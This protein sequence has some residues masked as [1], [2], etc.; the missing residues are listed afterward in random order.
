MV[1]EG[2]SLGKTLA[3]IAAELSLGEPAVSRALSHMERLIGLQIVDRQRYRLRLTPT[4]RDL[5]L[6]AGQAARQLRD[7]DDLV[8]RYRRGEAGRLRVLSSNAPASY[9]LPQ[10]INDFLERFP[11][12]EIQLDVEGA[13]NIWP[14]FAEGHHDVAVGPAEGPENVARTFL[15]DGVWC[16]EPLY[17]DR[18]VLFVSAA[19]PLHGRRGITLQALGAHTIVGT[20]G[21][22]DW[23]RLLNRLAARG[24]KVGRVVALKSVEGVKRLVESGQGVGVY[25]LSAIVR[26]VREG[27][28]VTLNLPDL[29]PPYSYILVRRASQGQVPLV[30]AFCQLVRSR[31]PEMTSLSGRITAGVTPEVRARPPR[32]SFRVP[33]DSRRPQAGRARH[34]Q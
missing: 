12:A 1:L 7:F 14:A 9:L 33:S 16:S 28:L 19:H 11:K 18:I 17:D 25:V 3:Q 30:G 20:F 26:E 34:M 4:G 27:R 8:E 24:L 22:A 21:E 15:A 5:A 32:T 13:H 29:G 10:V 31:L 2:L 23:T 6:A